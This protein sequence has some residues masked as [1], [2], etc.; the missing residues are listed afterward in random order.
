MGMNLGLAIEFGDT[1]AGSLRFRQAFGSVFFLEQ[2]LSL[3]IAP[4]DIVAIHQ[5]QGSYAGAS[6]ESGDGGSGCA[7]A[8]DGDVGSKEFLLALLPN[9]SKQDLPRVAILRGRK[10]GIGS[11]RHSPSV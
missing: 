6:Q 2:H 11:D 7:A 4:L 8:N 10:G 9:A 1:A 3:Q 5:R